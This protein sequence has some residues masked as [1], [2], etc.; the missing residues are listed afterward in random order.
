MQTLVRYVSDTC[1]I[2]VRQVVVHHMQDGSGCEHCSDHDVAF[3]MVI[4]GYQGRDGGSP[5]MCE[6]EGRGEGAGE[7]HELMLVVLTR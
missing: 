5:V 3:D 7:T 2:G 4:D 6:G 1:Q